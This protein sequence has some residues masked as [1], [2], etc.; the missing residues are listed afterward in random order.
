MHSKEWVCAILV[1]LARIRAG[2]LSSDIDSRAKLTIICHFEEISSQTICNYAANEYMC[3]AYLLCPPSAKFQILQPTTINDEQWG[4]FPGKYTSCTFKAILFSLAC[5]R[6]SSDCTAQDN[7][8]PTVNDR[9]RGIYALLVCSVSYAIFLLLRLALAR[10]RATS[11][12]L[13]CPQPQQETLK[14]LSYI[15]ALQLSTASWAI[16]FLPCRGLS[17]LLWIWC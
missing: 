12:L 6:E 13:A 16:F 4:T 2:L 10:I 8:R 5:V 3:T 15:Y 1:S 9:S 14:G 11:A 17:T 7:K